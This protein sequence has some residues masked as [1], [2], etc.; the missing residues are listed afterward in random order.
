[1]SSCDPMP[2]LETLALSVVAD[3]ARPTRPRRAPG[4]VAPARAHGVQG[5]GGRS[6]RDIVEVIERPGRLDQHRHRLSGYQLPGPRP[7][8]RSRPGAGRH[9]RPRPPPHA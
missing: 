3:A 4:L 1:M 9:R 5:A 6:A 8:G 2:G 7:E